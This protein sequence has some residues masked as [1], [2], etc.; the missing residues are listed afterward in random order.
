M[1]TAVAAIAA[2]GLWCFVAPTSAGTKP[3]DPCQNKHSNAETQPCYAHEQVRVNAEA[4][5]LANK[6]ADEFR[7]ESQ[8]SSDGPVISQLMQKAASAV[9]QSQKSW[10]EYRDQHC[11]AVKFSFTTGSGAGTEHESCLFKLGQQRVQELRSYFSL[12]L[13]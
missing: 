10:K 11:N 1:K 8:D 13:P 9:V 2:L 5:L 4:D 6:I 7:K 12:Y 3:H